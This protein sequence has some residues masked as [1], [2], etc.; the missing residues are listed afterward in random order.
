M[1]CLLALRWAVLRFIYKDFVL[2]Q[3][4]PSNTRK[5]K[6]APLFLDFTPWVEYDV[7]G[8]NPRKEY[9]SWIVFVDKKT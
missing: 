9:K 2:S 6:G 3:E 8:E 5:W 7:Y 1:I 4:F